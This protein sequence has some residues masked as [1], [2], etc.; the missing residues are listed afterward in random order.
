MVGLAVLVCTGCAARG[1]G[2]P[3]VES[4]G[5]DVEHR[6]AIR[7]LRV[8]TANLWGVSVLGIDV[9]DDI[10]ARFAAF[11]DRLARGTPPLDIVLLQ[12][13]WDDD[14]RRRLLEHAGVAERFPWRVDAVAHPGGAGLVILSSL[15]IEEV[16]FHRF[17]AQGNCFKFWEGDCASGKGVLAAR[18]R[19]GE[20]SYW[21][22]DTHLIACYQPA[23]PLEACDQEDPN[24][25]ARW[26][27][28][29]EL[30]SFVDALAPDDPL[31]VGGDFNFVPRSRY[32]ES[33]SEDRNGAAWTDPGD[34]DDAPE[35]LDYIW[36]RAG[37]RR[38]WSARGP[39]RPIATE[40][41]AT[42]SGRQVP[43]S[44]H[45]ILAVTLDFGPATEK[46]DTPSHPAR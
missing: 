34:V 32:H 43:V 33:L 13:A 19:S 25:A 10:D 15:P 39:L 27:Q 28:L 8:A 38:A 17:E 42:A 21:I 44:D 4:T 35:R 9:A 45:P 36:T 29:R 1:T 12:E 7:E 26:A 24:G 3:Q 30:R 40:P 5:L 2:V 41:V 46:A 37:T 31:I 20:G 18:V 6:V 14:A 11:A 23:E 16:R 22:A